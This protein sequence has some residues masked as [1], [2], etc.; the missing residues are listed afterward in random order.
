MDDE[1]DV[2][3]VYI[4]DKGYDAYRCPVCKRAY[5]HK[6]KTCLCGQ[7]IDWRVKNNDK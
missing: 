3:K 1:K 2:L 5:N 4:I 6:I 7:K